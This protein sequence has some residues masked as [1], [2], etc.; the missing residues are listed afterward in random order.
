MHLYSFNRWLFLS[1]LS[2]RWL[3]QWL[4]IFLL[5]GKMNRSTRH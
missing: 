1:Y 5:R 3:I 4:F 2:T